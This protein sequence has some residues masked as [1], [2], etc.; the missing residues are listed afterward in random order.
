MRFIGGQKL[1]DL[2]FLLYSFVVAFIIASLHYL[3]ML[4]DHDHGVA[5][6]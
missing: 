2:L 6:L 3:G 5:Q 1:L 4:A